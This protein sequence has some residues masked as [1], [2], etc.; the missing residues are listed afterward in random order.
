[1]PILIINYLF[2]M[3]YNILL[4][5]YTLNTISFFPFFKIKFSLNSIVSIKPIR[6]NLNETLDSDVTISFPVI[7]Q[8]TPHCPIVV[9]VIVSL[10]LFTDG[11]LGLEA[12]LHAV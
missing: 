11:Y 4:I 7:F 10:F 9:I 12:W 2:P 5:I 6:L 1:M 8:N 3:F